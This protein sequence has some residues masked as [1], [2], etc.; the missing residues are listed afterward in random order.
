MLTRSAMSHTAG[1]IQKVV[2]VTTTSAVHKLLTLTTRCI[3]EVSIIARLARSRTHVQ[4]T[5]LH[6]IQINRTRAMT[7]G[8]RKES[9]LIATTSTVE[10]LF[11]SLAVVIEVVPWEFTPT[12]TNCHRECAEPSRCY[13]SET[14]LET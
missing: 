3:I 9:V 1:H 7:F 4:H 8:Q 6:R 10:K 13:N 5:S 12:R 2:C 11:A 14:H